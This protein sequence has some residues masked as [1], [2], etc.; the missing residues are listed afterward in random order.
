MNWGLLIT[1]FTFL[2][3]G[4]WLVR[5]SLHPPLSMKLRHSGGNGKLPTPAPEWVAWRVSLLPWS[6]LLLGKRMLL[7]LSTS[8]EDKKV[9]KR[10][11]PMWDAEY[12]WAVGGGNSLSRTSLCRAGGEALFL[13]FSPHLDT[14][15]YVGQWTCEVSFGGKMF[16]MLF[17][18]KCKKNPKKQLR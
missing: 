9:A 14:G 3:F 6:G 1:T 17:W 2:G 8:R 18:I 15:F 4:G 11:P 12:K 5:Q 7:I 13:G 16:T 10:G